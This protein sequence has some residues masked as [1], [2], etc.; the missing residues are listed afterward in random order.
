MSRAT[1]SGTHRKNTRKAAATIEKQL[2]T[3][4]SDMGVEDGDFQIVFSSTPP[5]AALRFRLPLED[6]CYATV[7]KQCVLQRDATNNLAALYDWLHAR[8]VGVRAGVETLSEG[9]GC[10]TDYENSDVPP[11]WG[12]PEIGAQITALPMPQRA[13]PAPRNG[14]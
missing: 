4:L 11:D 6:E 5:M 3:V 2:R 10:H 14:R 7:L 1:A 12:R 9:F 13:L 8:V